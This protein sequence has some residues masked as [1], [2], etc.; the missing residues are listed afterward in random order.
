MRFIYLY[1][2]AYFALV[3]GAAFSLWHAG[4]LGRL[5][6]EWIAI[7]AIV[8]IGLGILLAVTAGRPTVTRN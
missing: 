2:L 4:V 6:A 1:L 5:P 7:G 3:V 8:T